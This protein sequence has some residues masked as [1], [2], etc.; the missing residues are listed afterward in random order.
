MLPPLCGCEDIPE[1]RGRAP[2]SVPRSCVPAHYRP[3]HEPA[4]VCERRPRPWAW[5]GVYQLMHVGEQPQAR[6]VEPEWGLD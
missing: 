2:L 3:T 6:A 4:H 1:V 5:Q